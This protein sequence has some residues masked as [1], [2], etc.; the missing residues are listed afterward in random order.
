MSFR[1]VE[2]QLNPSGRCVPV[3]AVSEKLSE[4]A[5]EG[6]GK[7]AAQSSA[8]KK[9]LSAQQNK[10]AKEN[11]RRYRWRLLKSMLPLTHFSG[12][13]S[14]LLIMGGPLLLVGVSVLAT[15]WLP[16]LLLGVLLIL[17]GL[18]P[19]TNWRSRQEAAW[20]STRPF[21]VLGY[22]DILGGKSFTTVELELRFRDEPPPHA[23][24]RDVVAAARWNTSVSSLKNNVATISVQFSAGSKFDEQR[25]WLRSW[26]RG[27]I[28]TLLVE[29]HNEYPVESLRF[30][31]PSRSK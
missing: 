27:F 7:R 31:A 10:A 22:P 5:K 24:L 18:L 17:V 16:P 23:L 25:A 26:S 20:A 21:S 1:E 6:R 29:L 9:S 14:L 12:V 28:D 11:A 19:Y 3:A 8:K 4:L 15:L 2:F 13:R 30:P